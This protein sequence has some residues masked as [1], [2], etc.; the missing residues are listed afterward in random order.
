MVHE[1]DGKM[2]YTDVNWAIY[3][4]LDICE[5]LKRDS[6]EIHLCTVSYEVVK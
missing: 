1:R 3:M 5:E 4:G 2:R 6:F